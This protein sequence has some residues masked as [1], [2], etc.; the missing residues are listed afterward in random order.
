MT[1]EL[2]IDKASDNCQCAYLVHFGSIK[3]A[4]DYLQ[5]PASKL[6]LSG[7]QIYQIFFGYYIEHEL[8]IGEYFS[9]FGFDDVKIFL[10]RQSQKMSNKPTLYYNVISP[11]C[12][13]VLLTAA[14]LGIELEL[15]EINLVAG[16]HLTAEFIKVIYH[17]QRGES[18]GSSNQANH[19]RSILSI[20][21]QHSMTTD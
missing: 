9:M 1:I 10:C 11:P 21:S 13:S 4:V 16:E 14:A 20:H 8:L 17:P 12:R 15:K 19:F 18:H 7:F 6:A 5:R 3:R 2:V